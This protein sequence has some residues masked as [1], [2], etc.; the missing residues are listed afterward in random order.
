MEYEHLKLSNKIVIW[1]LS[2]R[3]SLKNPPKLIRSM[4]R[5][6]R[7]SRKIKK[8]SEI[9]WDTLNLLE[10]STWGNGLGSVSRDLMV[11]IFHPSNMGDP[12]MALNQSESSS[13]SFL[14]SVNTFSMYLAFS[15]AMPPSSARAVINSTSR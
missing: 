7:I 15:M 10:T 4:R 12:A 9:S 8:T 2:A 11:R 14:C 6:R 13:I 3:N 1:R 5:L